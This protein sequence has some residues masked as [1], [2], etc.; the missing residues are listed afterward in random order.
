MG[1]GYSYYIGSFLLSKKYSKK[2]LFKEE[3]KQVEHVEIKYFNKKA[4][5]A[6]FLVLI[7]FLLD[8]AAMYVLNLKGGDATALLGGTALLLIVI[9]NVMN[10]KKDCLDSVCNNVVDGFVFGIKIFGAIIPIAA[11]LLYG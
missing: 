11:F 5:I 6:T 9:I 10:H 1:N 7:C 4:K 2:G 3:L 8:I